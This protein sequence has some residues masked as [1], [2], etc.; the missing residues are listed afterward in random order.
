MK[1]VNRTKVD[2]VFGGVT[3]APGETWEDGKP[4]KPSPKRGRPRKEK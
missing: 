3:I 2:Q 1:I 4:T